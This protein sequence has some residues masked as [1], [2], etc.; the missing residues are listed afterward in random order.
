MANKIEETIKSLPA[1]P[2]FDKIEALESDDDYITAYE[3][4]INKAV[5]I[6]D[7]AGTELTVIF[8]RN[9]TLI[10]AYDAESD[11]NYYNG[12]E[13]TQEQQ[14]VFKTLPETLQEALQDLNEELVW[15]WDDTGVIWATA[16]FWNTGEGWECDPEWAETA[17][18]SDMADLLPLLDDLITA[19]GEHK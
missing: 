8:S 9:S 3:S 19:T 17:E 11:L 12:E 13:A 14:Q 6:V 7:G 18:N 10:Y 15:D 16:A 5:R 2:G 4:G 1:T